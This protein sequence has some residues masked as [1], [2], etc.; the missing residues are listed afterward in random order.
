MVSGHSGHAHSW[1]HSPATSGV[2]EQ[3]EQGTLLPLIGERF[4]PPQWGLCKVH[5]DHHIRFAY[6][7]YSVPTAYIGRQVDVRKDSQLVRLYLKGELIK[8]HPAMAPGQRS[9]DFDD[10]PKEKTPM[11]CESAP[12][13]LNRLAARGKPAI[14]S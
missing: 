8:T 12:I 10:Y 3:E 9:T 13:R 4:D 1:N 11:P 5:P 2:F 6:A 14:S 7:L